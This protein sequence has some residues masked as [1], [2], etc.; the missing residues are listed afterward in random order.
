MY[1]FTADT[2]T[3]RHGIDDLMEEVFVEDLDFEGTYTDAVLVCLDRIKTA[4]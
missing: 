2:I 4:A 1:G 3:R